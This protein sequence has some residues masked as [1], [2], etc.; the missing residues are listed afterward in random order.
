M[1]IGQGQTLRLGLMFKEVVDLLDECYEVCLCHMHLH[2]SFVNLSQ[3]HH[4][5]DEAQDTFGISFYSFI[6]TFALWVFLIL[7]Q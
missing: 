5:V 3:I 7:D 4:L 1:F 6:D 2:L